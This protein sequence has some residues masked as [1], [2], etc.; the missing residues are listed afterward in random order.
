MRFGCVSRFLLLLLPALLA[1]A[2][3]AKAQAPPGSDPM[4]EIAKNLANPV[5][6]LVNVPFQSNWDYN[7]GS[8]EETL[9]TLNVQPVIPINLDDRY[10]LITRTIVPYVSY[11]ALTPFTPGAGGLSDT[12]LSVF[13]STRETVKGWIL[14]AGPVLLFPTATSPYTGT[15]KWAAGPT[16]VVGRQDKAWTLGLL[17]NQMWS[18]AGPEN[19]KSVN[20][21]FLEPFLMYTTKTYTTF[22]VFTET[23]YDFVGDSW[24]VPVDAIVSQVLM[25]GGL[26][27]SVTVGGR[28][29][30]ETPAGGPDWGFRLNLTL[31]F[32]KGK[33]KTGP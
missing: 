24:K 5:A 4:A 13:L 1:L 17:A 16:I 10:M 26:P 15:G 32:E 20:S 7:V 19:R 22:G 29:W 9:Y 2:P 27:F 21:L 12:Q 30:A 14:G 11:H 25:V 28:Y 31:I 3:P 23:S 18:F 8:T 6:N 33:A